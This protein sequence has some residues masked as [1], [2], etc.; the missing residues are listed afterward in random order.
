[1]RAAI[2]ALTFAAIV[3]QAIPWVP[4]DVVDYTGLPVLGRIHQQDTFGSDTVADSYESRVVLTDVGDMYTKDKTAQTALES[5]YWS[6][7]ASAPYPPAT[8]L[9]EAALYAL[10]GRTITGFYVAILGLAAAFLTMSLVYCLRTR[11]YI[12]PLLYLNFQFLGE[13]FVGVQDCSYL[14]MLVVVMAALFAA[15]ARRQAAHLLI[16]LAI[17]IKLSPLFYGTEIFRMPRRTALLFVAIVAAGLVLPYFVWTNYAYIYSFEAG[18]KG[19]HWNHVFAW[20]LTPLFAAAVWYV[21][22]RRGFDMEDRVG[23][24]LIP[25]AIFLGLYTNGARHLVLALL[26]PDKR[27]WRNVPVPITLLLHTLF[28]RAIPLGSVLTISIGMLAV[29]LAGYAFGFDRSFSHDSRNVAGLS[30]S[31]S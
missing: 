30:P 14:V 15:R 9:L 13:R 1:M 12:F 25:M 22:W 23:W 26:V 6:K 24:G 4:R 7:A 29:I 11:W 20:I 27:L 31:S 8:L 16:A 18:L 28:P 2:L 21:E 10:A 17:T 19:S 3:A 5:H